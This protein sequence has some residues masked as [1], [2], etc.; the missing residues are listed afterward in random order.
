M[1]ISI[2]FILV[3]LT[4]FFGCSTTRLLKYSSSKEKFYKDYNSSAGNSDI[5]ITLIDES[6]VYH[7]DHSVIRNDTLYAFQ[8]E[9]DAKNY[10]IPA[11]EIKKINYLTNDYKNA[12]L[13]LNDGE[14]LVAKNILISDDSIHFTGIREL[15]VKKQLNPVDDI[16]VISYKNHWKG[17][18]PGSLSGI[19]L[20]GLLGT[21]GWILHP[22]DDRGHFAQAE[23]TIAGALS[24]LIIGGVVGYILGFNV[25][26]QFTP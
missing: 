20:G 2:F 9:S 8:R 6:I 12:D 11:A 18:V 19:L 13:L 24:G 16:K 15:I 10:N 5:K 1:K 26:Y 3:A 17:V 23:A 25:N 21:S 7:D 14:R 22:P 4:V